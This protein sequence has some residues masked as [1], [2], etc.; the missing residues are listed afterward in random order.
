[1]RKSLMVV[2]SLV[3]SIF[4]AQAFADLKPASDLI[5]PAV[6]TADIWN[7]A[8]PEHRVIPAQEEM[9]AMEV[10]ATCIACKRYTLQ[11]DYHPT[12]PELRNCRWVCA[13]KLCI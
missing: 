3:A 11:C 6:L 1:M 10:A 8:A 5:E 12:A 13:E 2:V 9:G 4:A 7:K